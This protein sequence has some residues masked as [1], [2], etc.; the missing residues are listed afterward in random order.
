M[1][2]TKIANLSDQVDGS[3]V[4]FLVPEVYL[5]GTLNVYLNGQRLVSGTVPDDDFEEIA[6]TYNT[7]RMCVTPRTN[8]ILQVQ[9][10]VDDG[11]TTVF[12]VVQAYSIDP[13][14]C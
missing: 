7:F 12:P 6:P 4:V 13:S 10:E 5:A 2:S 11:V 3:A 8:C 9:Y 14:D 1:S